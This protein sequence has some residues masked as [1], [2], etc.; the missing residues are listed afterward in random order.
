MSRSP[1]SFRP[2]AALA[3]S[4]A[5]L[6]ALAV[7]PSSAATG[8]KVFWI[9]LSG[10]ASQH[11]ERVYFTANSGGYLE[12]ITWDGW[13]EEK[14]VGNGTFGTTA[15]CNGNPCPDGPGT[16]T[17]RKPVKCTPEFGEKKGKT[18]RV[19]RHGKLVYPDGEGGTETA[20][21]SDRTGWGSCKEND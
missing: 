14:A 4:V 6:L 15:P 18:V 9:D 11:P 13:G 3:L 19:Y 5:A 2:G 7:A 16:L 20:N 17:L 8:K 1:R 10:E 21:V 12:D